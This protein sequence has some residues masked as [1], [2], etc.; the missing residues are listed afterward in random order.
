MK[1]LHFRKSAGWLAEMKGTLNSVESSHP[2]SFEINFFQ[3]LL[4][5]YSEN[6]GVNYRFF[7]DQLFWYKYH[8]G[9]AHLTLKFQFSKIWKMISVYILW[10]DNWTSIKY[11][12]NILNTKSFSYDTNYLHKWLVQ[13]NFDMPLPSAAIFI[14]FLQDS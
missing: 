9:F 1:F 13:V 5:K 14:F 7:Q 8:I 2:L 11:C 4:T 12:S 6:K 10:F 3:N